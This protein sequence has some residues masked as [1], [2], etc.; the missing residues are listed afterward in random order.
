MAMLSDAR[1]VQIYEALEHQVSNLSP[2]TLLPSEHDLARRFGVS[3][4]T[5]RRA[6]G[7]LERNGIVSRQRG[8]GTIVS[9]PKITRRLSPMHSFEE[10]LRQQGI[11]FET[12]V[13]AYAPRF[14]PPDFVLDRLHV[15]R[16]STVG[17]L[18]LLR[19]VQGRVTCVGHHYFPPDLAEKFDPSIVVSR[20]VTDAIC[21]IAGM[22]MGTLEWTTEI[23]AATRD[24]AIPLGITPGVL[25]FANTGTECLVNAS[26]IQVAVMNYRIDRVKFQFAVSYAALP[27]PGYSRPVV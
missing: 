21:D 7:L 23:V 18:S 12:R 26:P 2:D 11:P 4:V 20:P 3:R 16:T 13:L 24:V 6:L 19:F 10:D 15:P 5:I 14:R 25:V 8:R 9:P 22:P 17:L 1:Y 27:G